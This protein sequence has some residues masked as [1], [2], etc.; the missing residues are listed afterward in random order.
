MQLLTKE[1]LASLPKIYAT[2]N[3][4]MNAL[5]RVKFFMP[6][7]NWTWYAAEFDGEDT[8]FGLV[9]GFAVEVGYFS[10]S[11]IKTVRGSLG[12]EVERDLYFKPVSLKQLEAL[13]RRAMIA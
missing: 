2:E 10:L 1:V 12:L 8:F 6:D 9:A 13:H 7:G 4:G 5:A 11:E 3:E